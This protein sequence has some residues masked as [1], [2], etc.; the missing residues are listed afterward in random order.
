MD[1]GIARDG[2]KPGDVV[3][4]TGGG[5]GFGR[6]FCKRFARGGAKVAVWE[7]NRAAGEETL[8]QI[9]TAG[10]EA[11]FFPVDLSDAKQITATVEQTLAA[12][13][14]PYLIINNA[15]IYPRA[16]V[17]DMKVEDWERTLRVNITAPFLIVRAFGPHMLK[18]KRGVVINI[19]SGR[20]VQG[21]P[22]GANYACSKAAILSLTKTLALEWASQ[23][24]RVNA[25]IPGVSMTAQPLENTTPQE[26]AE[27]GRKE[28]PLG[29]IG[30]PDDM[31]GLAAFLASPDAA[32]MTGQAVAMNGGRVLVP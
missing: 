27:R 24:V 6:A 25:I 16:S 1:D 29:R 10:G 8:A 32:Y 19:A 22:G 17:I 3:V 18:Q 2:I 23:N 15:S 21:A 4:V 12:Y 13:G 31:A 28:I 5:G 7:I 9:K 20:G 26:L 11:R 30:Y 14:T